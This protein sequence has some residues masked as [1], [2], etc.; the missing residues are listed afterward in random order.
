VRV[1]RSCICSLT[2]TSITAW[3]PTGVGMTFSHVKKA[4][5]VPGRVYGPTGNILP[6][7]NVVNKGITKVNQPRSGACCHG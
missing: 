5:I 6:I 7:G 4:G 3:C 1:T 2:S